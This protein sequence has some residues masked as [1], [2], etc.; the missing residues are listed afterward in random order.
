MFHTAWPWLCCST[1]LSPD[2]VSCVL[3]WPTWCVSACS[4]SPFPSRIGP[5]SP[6]NPMVLRRPGFILGLPKHVRLNQTGV[7]TPCKPTQSLQNPPGS[8][9]RHPPH[10]RFPERS[11]DT[12]TSRPNPPPL[13]KNV[14]AAVMTPSPAG[15]EGSAIGEGTYLLLPAVSPHLCPAG[16][17]TSN[18]SCL[19]SVVTG[20]GD[21]YDLTTGVLLPRRWTGKA[22]L[23]LPFFT[24]HSSSWFLFSS[25]Y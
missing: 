21:R 15:T 18:H 6:P 9:P 24:P 16:G 2:R 8:D 11:D 5:Q 12:R 3:A 25:A 1:Q 13:T 4:V 10:G 22:P 14:N 19:S 23:L 7:Q 17:T 20:S